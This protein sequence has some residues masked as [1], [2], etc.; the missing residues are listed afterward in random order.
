MLYNRNVVLG[1]YDFIPN[2]E[3]YRNGLLA[4]VYDLLFNAYRRLFLYQLITQETEYVRFRIATTRL[5]DAALFLRD[6]STQASLDIE[7]IFTLRRRFEKRYQQDPALVK[8]E[9]ISCWSLINQEFERAKSLSTDHRDNGGSNNNE[10][11][12]PY[13]IFSKPNKV[14]LIKFAVKYN[15]CLSGISAVSQ[16]KKVI[17]GIEVILGSLKYLGIPV[18]VGGIF[19]GHIILGLLISLFFVFLGGISRLVAI[20]I[21]K[22]KY[23]EFSPQ[24]KLYFFTLAP[25]YFGFIYTMLALNFPRIGRAHV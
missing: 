19:S 22:M 5:F 10:A 14:S 9:V 17:L 25:L 7:Q 15:E 23:P 18:I 4:R 12:N 11:F 1:G 24:L 13:S 21:F 8:Q 2:E 16:L 6:Y 20:I 3:F